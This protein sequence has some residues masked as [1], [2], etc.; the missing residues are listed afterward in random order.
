MS[1]SRLWTAA[2][3]FVLLLGFPRTGSAGFWDV[4]IEMS[5]PKMYGVS[6]DCRLT[7]NGTWD[8]CKGSGPVPLLK[9]FTEERVSKVWLSFDGGYYWSADATVNEQHY[10]RGEVKMF[11]FDPMLEFE[12]KS[13]KTKECPKGSPTDC[14]RLRLQIYH[15][16]IGMSYN[17]LFGADF[18]TFSNVGL[19]LR[20]FGIA[21]PV[22]KW[23]R[24]DIAGDF[25][26][27]LRLYPQG[28]TAEDFGHQPLRPEGSGAEAVHAVVFGARIKILPK[29]TP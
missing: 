5:G 2:C 8:S 11:L 13:W 25:S 20:P 17:I 29:G 16:V 12:S 19:K 3:V 15:G 22:R 18:A 10:R 7:L 14:E 24:L 23:K 21:V 28:F 9:A 4:I 27:D 26:Y 6:A 1:P